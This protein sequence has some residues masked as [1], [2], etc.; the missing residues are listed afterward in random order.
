MKIGMIGQKRVPSRE[1]GVEVVVEELSVRM[2][3]LG[4]S[5]ELYNRLE[6]YSKSNLKSL[7]KEYKGI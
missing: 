2:A 1:G 3:V 4:H 6:D 7:K 5:V